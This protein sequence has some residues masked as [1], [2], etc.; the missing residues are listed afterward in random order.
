MVSYDQRT[1]ELDFFTAVGRKKEN[2][3]NNDP[4]NEDLPFSLLQALLFIFRESLTPAFSKRGYRFLVPNVGQLISV[5]GFDTYLWQLGLN[6]LS[7][8][9]SAACNVKKVL[10][11]PSKT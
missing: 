11:R 7:L 1:R 9:H 4:G 3:G 6:I 10:D 2:K 5:L 8:T